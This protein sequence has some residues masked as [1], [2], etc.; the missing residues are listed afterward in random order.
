MT[1]LFLPRTLPAM[2]RAGTVLCPVIV[3]RDDVL[4]LFDHAVA[5]T[6]KGRG[7]TLF[8]AGAAGLG[9]TRLV[10][11]AIRKAEAAGLRVDGGSVAPQ[12]LQVA[13]GSIREFANGLRGS[14]E[15]GTLSEDLLAIDGRH[16]GDALGS[17]RL[18]VRSV[19][20][21]ILEA[22]DRPTLLV[23]Q[24]LH[25]TDEMSLEVI[26]ELARHAADLPLLILGDYRSD[27]FP[28]GDAVH[29]EWR[30]RLLSQ[31]HAEEVRLRNLTV[32]ET[33]VATTLILGGELPAPKDVVAAVHARTNGIP[34]HIEELLAALDDQTRADGRLIRDARVP[35]TIGDAVLAQVRPAVR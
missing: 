26:G 15:W 21:R 27:E 7:R 29:R 35:D 22:I 4:E 10:R 14:T 32:E 24:D 9:K 1:G 11:A 3:G 19:A 23:F 34:L 18:I 2:T 25:W 6:V 13:L 8:L 16:D 28:G 30:A 31:R 12:D 5:E 33:G 20:D 17:R